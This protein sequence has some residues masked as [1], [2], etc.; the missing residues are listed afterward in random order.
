MTYYQSENGWPFSNYHSDIKAGFKQCENLAAI[1][2]HGS[3]INGG[4]R[5]KRTANKFRCTNTYEAM[6]ECGYYCHNYEFTITI[7]LINGKFEYV[8][9]NFHGQHELSCCGYG[10]KD[11][12]EDTIADCISY[13]QDKIKV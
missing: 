4:W 8:R 1:L 10:I 7:K 11:Y 3:G 12:L 5:I 13:N 2:P 9:L 6:N